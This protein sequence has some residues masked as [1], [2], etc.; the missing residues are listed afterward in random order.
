LAESFG[1]NCE[2]HGNGA[3]AL[4]VCA[5]IK[6]CR[7]YE[8]GLLHPHLEYDEVPAYLH[9]LSDPMDQH[10]FVHLSQRPGL[11][12]DI[13]FEYIAGHAVQVY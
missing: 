10:G 6:N 11:G 8:R 9:N 5:T 2:V 1:M 13:N 3:A 7:W 4:A 12:E